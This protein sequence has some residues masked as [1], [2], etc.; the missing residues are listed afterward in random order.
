MTSQRR[1]V[2]APSPGARPQSFAMSAAD[3]GLP[4]ASARSRR[5]C[6]NSEPVTACTLGQL[7]IRQR[8]ANLGRARLPPRLEMSRRD[9]DIQ[10]CLLH[11]AVPCDGQ[12]AAARVLRLH[13]S[14][15]PVRRHGCFLL[16]LC[17]DR[18][19]CRRLVDAAISSPAVIRPSRSR[20]DRAASNLNSPRR[21]LPKRPPPA[22]R[23]RRM[24]KRTRDR[25]A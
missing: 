25:R 3:S 9:N 17:A 11:D 10:G 7:R 15:T 14:R 20:P 21:P 8:E 6:L 24:P 18:G 5:S 4:M 1:T 22:I 19:S 23:T 16:P 2:S 13:H 12:A